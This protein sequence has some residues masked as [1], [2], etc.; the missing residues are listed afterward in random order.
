VS[1]STEAT[2]DLYGRPLNDRGVDESGRI[3]VP[4]LKDREIAE[5]TLAT[6]RQI[7]D[8]I[9]QIGA[10]PSSMMNRFMPGMGPVM[11]AINGKK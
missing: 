8:V 7:A 4:Y 6:L 10:N 9:S 5:E 2:I 3:L 1:E 11:D